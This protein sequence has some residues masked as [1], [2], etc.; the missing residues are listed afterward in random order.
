MKKEFRIVAL[1]ALPNEDLLVTLVPV[2]SVRVDQS[3]KAPD[4]ARVI[5]GPGLQT[6]EAKV[7]QE[8]MKGVWEELD[9]RFGAMQLQSVPPLTLTLTRQE[10]ED[11]GNP[12]VN[13]VVTLSVEKA[14]EEDE[15]R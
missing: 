2:S 3:E 4:P 10:Y 15:S 14:S 9:K 7:V 1:Q 8:M 13:Q 11:L 5:V 6:E 12:L